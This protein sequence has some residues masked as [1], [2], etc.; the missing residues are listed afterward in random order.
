MAASKVTE[1][2][3]P[4]AALVADAQPHPVSICYFPL[5]SRPCFKRVKSQWTQ[6]NGNKHWLTPVTAEDKTI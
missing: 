2:V 6:E 4:I 5:V 3:H 1:V